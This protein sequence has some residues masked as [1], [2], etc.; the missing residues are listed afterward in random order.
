MMRFFFL[1]K[2]YSFIFIPNFTSET[3]KRNKCIICILTY[4]REP[5]ENR[6]WQH[7]LKS[8]PVVCLARKSRRT[9]FLLGRVH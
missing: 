8:I 7:P 4:I 1:I 9:R 3:N 6:A 2:F 5:G